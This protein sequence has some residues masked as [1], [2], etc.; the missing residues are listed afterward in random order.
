MRGGDKIM[1][2][3]ACILVGA[4]AIASACST[5]STNVPSD[6]GAI[7]SDV[8][9]Y[10][11]LVDD[12]R[13]AASGYETSMT[14]GS[15]T[16]DDCRAIHDQYDAHVRPHLARMS[17]MAPEM[18]HAMESHGG[19]SSADV[20]CIAA[21]M[22]SELD[23]HHAVA[24]TYAS[25]GEDR[26]EAQRHAN[27]MIDFCGHAAARCA[28]IEHGVDA[29]SWSWGSMMD[30][31]HDWHGEG[32]VTGHGDHDAGMHDDMQDSGMH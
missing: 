4:C 6:N 18:D 29:G 3:A 11:Q 14:D 12:T 24:C 17:G 32:G 19:M 21:A 23:R 16:T 28:E 26:A 1:K 20:A 8:T 9:T 15:V 7:A 31:C 2:T 22:A 25:I 13:A 30:G 10:Q 27:A 5:S